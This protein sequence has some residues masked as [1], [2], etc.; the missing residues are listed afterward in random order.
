MGAEALLDVKASD[1]F[2]REQEKVTRALAATR[3]LSGPEPI[4]SA[5]EAG[6]V[7][8]A[9]RELANARTDV[10]NKRLA[11]SA[12]YRATTD[13]INAT[14]NEL[15]APV[16]AAEE[17]LKD[18]ALA[19]Q[20][21]EEA[22]AREEARREQ[23]RVD[24]EAE[25]KA[26]EAQEAAEVA[27]EDPEFQEMADEAR[28]EA[29]A[30]AVAPPV[31]PTPQPKQVRGSLGKSGYRTVLNFDI[32]DESKVPDAF[33]VVS[34]DLLKAKIQTEARSAKAA[35]RN[36]DLNRDF[37]FGLIPGVR[38]YAKDIPVSR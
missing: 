6:R 35:N 28:Q 7:A 34:R 10:K 19:W 25:A 37:N 26:K 4:A 9:I 5:E 13:A 14:Y 22:R 24:A 27:A 3:P 21:A 33:K 31:Q 16:E 18:K 30:A 15:S 12:D 1:A 23:E 2:E 17:A 29:A 11:E 8:D 20:K 32:E 38:I 36:F